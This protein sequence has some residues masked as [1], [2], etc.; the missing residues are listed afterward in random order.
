[1]MSVVSC[2]P[3]P[4]AA[5]G[6]SRTT[7]KSA[8]DRPGPRPRQP[9]PIGH[10]RGPAVRV[11]RMGVATSEICCEPRVTINRICSPVCRATSSCR[12]RKSPIGR[13]F[14]CRIISPDRKPAAAAGDPGDTSPMCGLILCS[15]MVMAK[16]A[17]MVTDRMKLATGP[18]STTSARCQS[19][20]KSKYRRRAAGPSLASTCL[21]NSARSSASGMLAALS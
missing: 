10:P 4:S 18:A 5:R 1:M 7:W 14:A 17:K 19:G 9:M 6:P 13:P 16:T 3:C 11:L 8:S 20:L 12:S 21:R 2:T 15:P